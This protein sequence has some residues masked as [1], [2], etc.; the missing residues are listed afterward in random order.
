M[1]EQV[2]ITGS[3]TSRALDGTTATTPS[4]FLVQQSTN[5]GVF[6]QDEFAY[7]QDAVVKL[8]YCPVARLK[9]TV[10]YSLMFWSRLA[11]PGDQIDTVIDQR[12][13]P[14]TVVP[15]P[16]VPTRPAFQFASSPFLVQGL[17]FGLEYRF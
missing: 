17:T 16:P 5:A 12:L 15:P 13:F 14:A 4:G 6:T 2:S 11:R 7:M 10:G 1:R 3:Q 9:L 8:G